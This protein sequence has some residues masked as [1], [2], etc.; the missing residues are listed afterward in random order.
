MAISAYFGPMRPNFLL[1]PPI[2][3]ALGAS[4]AWLETGQ[5][6]G[7]DLAL[8]LL[9]AILAHASVNMLNEFEDFS[10]G[11]DAMTDRTP[12]SGGSGTLQAHPDLA[13]YT[14]TAGI[15]TLMGTSAVG[16]YFLISRGVGLLPLGLLGVITV[17]AYSKW[18]VRS[19]LVSLV[20]PGLGFGPLMVVGTAF[21][22]T[23]RYSPLAFLV[24]LCP[25]FLVSGL[26]LLNQFPDTEPDRKVGRKNLPIVYGRDRA[27]TVFNVMLV[28]AFLPTLVGLLA[29]WLPPQ[30]ALGLLPVLAL[31][32]LMVGAARHADDIPALIPVMGL[33]VIT[34]LAS[35]ALLAI[36]I[37]WGAAGTGP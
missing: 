16:I 20:A 29:G 5:L 11:L 12:F 2:C 26:L 33:N 31:P 21:V 17:A 28:A 4:V 27:A 23:G 25:F 9:G 32:K 6:N 35:P 15:A 30:A 36:G 19:P 3:V 14:R 8:A 37:A 1:L 7:L 10:N 34:V 22:L 13:S 24:S 18:I